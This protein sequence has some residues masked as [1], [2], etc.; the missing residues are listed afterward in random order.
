[1]SSRSERRSWDAYVRE[2]REKYSEVDLGA[3]G[4]V[5]VYVP[6]STA[7]ERLSTLDAN[8][9][10]SQIDVLFGDENGAKLRRVAGDEPITALQ[11]LVTDV[12]R[13]LGLDDMGN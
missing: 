6:S 13:D 10:W 7:M 8:D 5:R 9:Q 3:E 2:S 4:V 11:A 1:M 12:M